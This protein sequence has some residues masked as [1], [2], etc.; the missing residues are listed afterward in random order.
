[1]AIDWVTFCHI[2]S[3]LTADGG[4]VVLEDFCVGAWDLGV[5][6]N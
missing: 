4:A 1:M 3:V 5:R 6:L 2:A